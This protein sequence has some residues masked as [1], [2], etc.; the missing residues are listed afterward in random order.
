MAATFKVQRGV[1]DTDTPP[2][3]SSEALVT[4]KVMKRVNT[5]VLL[6][7][8]CVQ[9]LEE[10]STA[11]LDQKITL[12]WADVGLHQSGRYLEGELRSNFARTGSLH[13]ERHIFLMSVIDT[14]TLIT[15]LLMYFDGLRLLCALSSQPSTRWEQNF[16]DLGFGWMR[17]IL[18]TA[19]SVHHRCK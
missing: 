14:H 16:T 9:S 15:Q 17:V 11:G 10:K 3:L 2:P 19:A 4:A 7:T 6:W 12:Y 1:A 5:L 8:G 13:K 18:L